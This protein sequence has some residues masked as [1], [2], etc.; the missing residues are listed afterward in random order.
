[1]EQL[2]I[3]TGAE[4]N[5]WSI[6]LK[7]QSLEVTIM[8]KL[9]LLPSNVRGGKSVIINWGNSSFHIITFKWSYSYL[10]LF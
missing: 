5:G 10:K 7:L 4:C 6:T 3:Y 2:L 9:Q 8:D 1:M